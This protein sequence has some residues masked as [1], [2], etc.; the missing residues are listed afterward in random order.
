MRATAFSFP[1]TVVTDQAT[2]RDRY[3]AAFL[4]GGLVGSLGTMA[5]YVEFD[6]S[7]ASLA[8]CLAASAK[9]IVINTSSFNCTKGQNNGEFVCRATAKR[10]GEKND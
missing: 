9:P 7:A 2:L 10:M 5:L 1:Q 4:I 6:T 3:S 8:T